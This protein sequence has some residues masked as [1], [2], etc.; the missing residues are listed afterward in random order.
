MPCIF[1]KWPQ[2][3]QPLSGNARGFGSGDDSIDPRVA[4]AMHG[5]SGSRLAFPRSGQGSRVM[6]PPAASAQPSPPRQLIAL[7]GYPRRVTTADSDELRN[8]LDVSE[9]DELDLLLHVLA[10]EA[11]TADVTMAVDTAMQK[12]SDDAWV[13]AATFTAVTSAPSYEV[14][15]VSGLMR[16]ARFRVHSIDTAPASFTIMGMGR[17]HGRA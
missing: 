5:S 13:T 3:T 9:F 7:T 8:A 15:N 14:M 17:R 6:P 11:G 2:G 10:F 16:Y 1:V 4:A 12:E